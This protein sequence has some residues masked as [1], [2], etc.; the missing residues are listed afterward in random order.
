MEEQ[1]NDDEFKEAEN[2]KKRPKIRGLKIALEKEKR[3]AQSLSFDQQL[4]KDSEYNREVWLE[5]VK[6]HLEKL[7][8][9]ANR[10]NQMLR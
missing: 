4:A 5:W 2:V 6:I 3:E 1:H 9:K 7:L 10:D 8:M